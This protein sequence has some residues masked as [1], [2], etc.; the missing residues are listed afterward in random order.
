MDALE[1]ALF[2]TLM[3][4]MDSV[5]HDQIDSTNVANDDAKSVEIPCNC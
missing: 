5:W 2:E 1:K 4:V 3:A